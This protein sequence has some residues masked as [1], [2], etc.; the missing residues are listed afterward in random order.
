M[1][2]FNLSKMQKEAFHDDGRGLM[3][4][5]TRCMQNCWKA[6][7]EGKKMG[8]QEAYMSCLEEYQTSKSN[9]WGVKYAGTENNTQ[10]K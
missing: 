8:A 3:Q 4:K 10:K 1:N 2:T 7:M 5:Q 6:K 9:D